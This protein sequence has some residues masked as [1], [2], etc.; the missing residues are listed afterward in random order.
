MLDLII[1]NGD[2]FIDGKI[3]TTTEGTLGSYPIA[4]PMLDMH[5]IGAGGGSIA[6][7]DEG[8]LLRVGPQSSGASP[9][10]ACMLRVD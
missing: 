6:F 7:I 4:V 10:P 5:T 2:C 3:E 8:G 9:G 1:K